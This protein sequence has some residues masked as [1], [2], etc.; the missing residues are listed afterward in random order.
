MIFIPRELSPL[1][2]CS[3]RWHSTGN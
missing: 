1:M 2:K 3:V